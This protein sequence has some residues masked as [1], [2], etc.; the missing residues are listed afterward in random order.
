[1][2]NEWKFLNYC[3]LKINVEED[4]LLLCQGRIKT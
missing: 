3:T 4:A 1:M 2:R